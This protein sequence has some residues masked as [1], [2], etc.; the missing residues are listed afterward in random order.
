MASQ[1]EYEVEKVLQDVASKNKDVLDSAKIVPLAPDW[2][3]CTN[4]LYL[5][6]ASAGCG[7]SRFIL[8]HI[9]MCDRLAVGS[10]KVGKVEPDPHYYSLIA[11]CSTSGELDQTVQ[12]YLD[13]NVIKTP[14]IQVKDNK[15][16]EFLDKHLKRKK[17]YYSMIKYLQKEKINETL[18]HS[19]DKHNFKYLVYD[20][21]KKVPKG[22]RQEKPF[23]GYPG[24][25]KDIRA[26]LLKEKVNK[27]KLMAWILNKIKEYGVSRTVC[28]PPKGQRSCPEGLI[29]F[30]RP[31]FLQRLGVS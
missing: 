29:F 3:F 4:G 27:P 26:Q 24:Q 12:S 18:Q 9:L 22:M 15:L 20:P 1:R 5:M 30:T 16:M 21:K 8:K 14:L 31:A 19:V 28:R 13:A 11:Y 6:L 23:T 10:N 2:L 7:K 17:K 25:E